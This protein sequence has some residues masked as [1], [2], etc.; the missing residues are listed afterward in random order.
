MPQ[1]TSVLVPFLY[2]R[3]PR[4]G[5]SWGGKCQSQPV[6]GRGTQH[7]APGT[8]GETSHRCVCVCLHVC[9]PCSDTTL[10]QLRTVILRVPNFKC[11]PARWDISYLDCSVQCGDPLCSPASDLWAP[12][13]PLLVMSTPSCSRARATWRVWHQRRTTVGLYVFAVVGLLS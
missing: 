3:E 12:L 9:V 5:C 10:H 4:R 1:S 7:S 11:P 13:S 8:P 6:L 2:S